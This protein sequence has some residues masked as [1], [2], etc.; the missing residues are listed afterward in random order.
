MHENA[1]N[2]PEFQETMANESKL[3]FEKR[4][5]Q[6]KP[7]L[8]IFQCICQVRIFIAKTYLCIPSG[9]KSFWGEPSQEVLREAP[10]QEVL[11]ET[12]NQEDLEEAPSQKF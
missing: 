5:E 6:D 8:D 7:K 12:P 2:Y 1:G 4:K 3:K 10:N 9:P 11:G